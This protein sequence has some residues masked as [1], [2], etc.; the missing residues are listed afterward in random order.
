MAKTMMAVMKPKAAPGV[1]IRDV[2]VPAFGDTDVLVKVRVASVCGTDLHIYDWDQWAERRIKPPLIPGH[3]FCGDVAA[4]GK[5]VTVVKEGDFVSAEMHVACGK[6][7]QCRTG[8]RH[9]CQHVKII[10]VDADGAFAEYVVIPESNIWKIDPSIPPEY[11]S[12]YDPLGNAVHTVLSG[13]IAAKTVAITGCG[14]IGLFS[15]AVARACGATQVFAIE[16]NEHRRKIAKQMKADFVLDPAKDDVKKIVMDA[17]NG[18]GVDVLLEMAGRQEAV[19]TGFS[20]LRL[21]GRASLLGIPSKP[22]TMNFAEDIIFKGATILGING[23]RMYQTWYQMEALLKAGK[24]DLHPVITDRMA[25]KDF[26]KGMAR[27]KTGEASKIL[28]YPNGVR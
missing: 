4:V 22:M 27:L 5:D 20:I 26:A 28:L 21:G 19:A 6:C 7:Y 14:P 25:M 2:K 17:T 13:D 9:I 8:E 11:A 18:V 1:E 3:E 24:L 15:I 16:V 12:L 23:R 10:G